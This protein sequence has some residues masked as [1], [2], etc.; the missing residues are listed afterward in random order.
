MTLPRETMSI[1]LAVFTLTAALILIATSSVLATSLK[2]ATVTRVIDGDTIE[3]RLLDGRAKRIR[4]IGMDTPELFGK[5]ECFGKEAFQY[6][7]SLVEGK[8]VWLEYDVQKKDKYGQAL[9]YVYLD[10][11]GSSMVNAILV[12]QGFAS[13][14]TYPP[15]VKNVDLFVRFQRIAR[16]GSRGLW[17]KCGE[18]A[19]SPAEPER[20]EELPPVLI[21][22]IH[23]DASG[24]DHSNENGEWLTLKARANTSLAG[25]TIRD[26]ADK[27]YHFP[28]TFQLHREESVRLYTGS[29]EQ[30]KDEGACGE[31][32]DR[33]LFWG[34][35]SAIW[36]NGG[37]TAYLMRSGDPV[38]SCSYSGQGVEAYCKE[39]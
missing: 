37:D 20:E 36:N 24:N 21:T 13:V 30:P 9:A 3:V 11:E 15:N 7:R 34:Y 14:A 28:E 31:N 26:E 27:R 16:Q 35:E 4:Y 23:F 32:P 22:C 8:T 33:E 18:T 6:N 5:P 39:K 2:E 10:P 19:K 29:P 17:S 12:V 25:W 1:K 38:D